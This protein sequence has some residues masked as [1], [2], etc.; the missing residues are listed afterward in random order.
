MWLL[1]QTFFFAIYFVGIVFSFTI[2]RRALN[3]VQA[4]A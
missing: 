1:G 3:V 2:V 4:Q